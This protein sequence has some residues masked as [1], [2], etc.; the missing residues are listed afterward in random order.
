[1]LI[2]LTVFAQ[3]CGPSLGSC[4]SGNCCSQWGWCGT[5]ATYCGSGCMVGYG[6]CTTAVSN[7][8]TCSATLAC[9]SGFCCS[10]YGYCGNTAEYC[11]TTTPT[12]PI[13]TD[14]TCNS[15]LDCPSGLCCSIHGY[16]G[17][18][19]AYC[20][21]ANCSKQC[22]ATST[23]LNTATTAKAATTT[24]KAA[25]TTV[26]ATTT[27]AAAN[28]TSTDFTCSATLDCPSGLCCSIYG[29]CG[30]TD[31][32]CGSDCQR[33]CT[34]TSS[35]LFAT[36]SIKTTATAKATSTAVAVPPPNLSAPLRN[37]KLDKTVAW[38]FDDGPDPALTKQLMDKIDA[39]VAA[40]KARVPITFFDIGTNVVANSGVASSEIS[41]GHTVADHSW[42]H[43]GVQMD[44]IS[45]ATMTQEATKA[46]DAIFAAT[47]KRTRFF[48]PPYGEYSSVSMG[49]WNGLGLYTINW[50]IDSND[51]KPSV[52]SDNSDAFLNIKAGFNAD[53]NSGHIILSHDIH[54]GSIQ[55]FD[56]IADD[57]EA[58]GYKFISLEDC[59]GIPPYM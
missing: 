33:Q 27:T 45:P 2:A 47:G 19:D 8:G 48:R 3:Q 17:T 18:T 14:G 20:K 4:S 12:N 7:D 11:G 5:G 15:K 51:W 22:P 41:R 36:G 55:Y 38:T 28:P 40:G 30:T 49:V 39:R 24:V 54:T 56:E 31:A 32:Y 57:I 16:C 46:S 53:S 43:L 25:T 29:Y 42:S 50:S 6:D 21:G 10:K 9:P 52:T 35:T 37:C 58:R 59:L 1:M 23:G 26:K 13:S 44:N 34:V